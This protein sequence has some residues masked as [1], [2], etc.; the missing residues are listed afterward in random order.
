MGAKG[1]RYFSH[2]YITSVM[3]NLPEQH[4]LK[5][6]QYKSA[7]YLQARIEL[8]QRFSTNLYGWFRWVFDQFDLSIETDLLEI[9]CGTGTLWLESRE[10]IPLE[11]HITLTDFSPG[12]ITDA[13]RNIGLNRNHFNYVVSDGMAIPFP[14]ESFTSVIANHVLYHIPDRRKALAEISRVLKPEGIF[15]A[16]TIGKNHLKE[17]SQIMAGF[18]PTEGKYYSSAL[19]PSG[20]TL[21]NGIRQLNPWFNSIEIRHYYDALVV[22]EAEPLLA[23]ILSMIPR[24][25]INDDN[26]NVIKLHDKINKLINQQGSIHIQKL[27]GIFIGRKKGRSN[28]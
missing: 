5:F 4:Y 10:R 16:T 8:H 9:G 2:R 19:N 15:F 1:I 18:A 13:K 6:E 11:W 7:E 26:S 23:Y 3:P 25:E 14:N 24:S 17:L 12:M 28:A 21:E 22:T 20:F 27:S